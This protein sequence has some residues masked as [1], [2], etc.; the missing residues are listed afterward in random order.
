MTESHRARALDGAHAH[1]LVRFWRW[2]V[3]SRHRRPSSAPLRLDASSWWTPPDGLGIDEPAP[4]ELR[5]PAR[6]LDGRD[7]NFLWGDDARGNEQDGVDALR[8]K[9]LKRNRRSGTWSVKKPPRGKRGAPKR[10]HAALIAYLTSERA[11][12]PW[13]EAD[14]LERAPVYPSRGADECGRAA[15]AVAAFAVAAGGGEDPAAAEAR[16]PPQGMGAADVLQGDIGDCYF[17][18][19]LSLLAEFY[20]SCVRRRIKAVRGRSGRRC[21]DVSMWGQRHGSCRTPGMEDGALTVRVTR[22]LYVHTRECRKGPAGTPLYTRCRDGSLWPCI[23]EKA[24]VQYRRG[25]SYEDVANA[26]GFDP[27]DVIHAFSGL[28]TMSVSVLGDGEMCRSRAAAAA[29]RSRQSPVQRMERSD[30]LWALISAAVRDGR[31]MAGGTYEAGRGGKGPADSGLILCHHS[32]AFLDAGE[33]PDNGRFVVMRNPQGEQT[34]PFL[35]STVPPWP[36]VGAVG[37]PDGHQMALD[38]VFRLRLEDVMACFQTITYVDE[39]SE[40]YPQRL[41]RWYRK[42]VSGGERVRWCGGPALHR[43]GSSAQRRLEL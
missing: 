1:E 39:V 9:I 34:S 30:E 18:C 3:P 13:Y 35:N 32:Y 36:P 43:K 7:P 14:E 5:V 8:R 2:P 4:G 6:A 24:W 33:C 12:A 19:A 28:S 23:L 26:M 31:A 37:A 16:A 22:A 17:A 15:F 11:A 29:I 10:A 40:A 41:R 42:F 25:D 21:F 20:P 27:G 38:G